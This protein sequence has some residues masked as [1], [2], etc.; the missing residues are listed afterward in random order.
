MDKASVKDFADFLDDFKD[1]Y[2]TTITEISKPDGGTIPLVRNNFRMFSFDDMCRR[3]PPMKA[4][5]PKTMDAL[6]Y[7]IDAKGKLTLYLIEFKTTKIE[8]KGEK[9]TYALLNAIHNK[10]KKLNNRTIDRY[11]NQKIIPDNILRNFTEI[12]N[13]FV[14]SIELD[15]ILKPMES[16]FIALPWLYD[17]Y[18][19]ENESVEKKDIRAF[20]NEID[21]KIFV[22]INRYAPHK[23]TSADRLSPH[24]IDNKLKSEYRRLCL[25]NVIADDKERIFSYDRFTYFI[26]KE[27]LM[28]LYPKS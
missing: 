9:S 23:N 26:K 18:C 19:K 16:I 25:S 21:I 17:E 11:S 22:F 4:L 24:P 14:D 15:L 7:E 3:Y 5:P 28:E 6:H 10:L 8:G 1:D 12:K 27:N 2:F 13:H 20:L